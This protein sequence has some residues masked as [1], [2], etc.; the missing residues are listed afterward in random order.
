M[1]NDIFLSPHFKL[2]EFVVSE[3]ASRH[4]IDN[5]PPEEAVENLRRLCQG[6]LEPLR[7]ALQ[8]PVVITSGFRTKALNDR[9]AHS[10]ERSQ[11]MQGCAAD[12]YVSCA[13]KPRF[14]AAEPRFKVQGSKVQGPRVDDKVQGSKVQG[15][16]TKVRATQGSMTKVQGRRELLIKAFR[17]IITSPEIDYDQLILYPN[18]IHVS[19]VSKER[20]RHNILKARSNGKLGYGKLSYANAIL[21]NY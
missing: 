3:T 16:L 13:A 9:L 19:Y 17:L 18:F 2:S 12:F 8:L 6:T 10:S 7:E 1:T 20:N 14:N 4:G 15:S 5:T 21:L 11:H